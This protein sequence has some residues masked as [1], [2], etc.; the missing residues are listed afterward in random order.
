MLLLVRFELTTSRLPM[1][2]RTSSVILATL[3]LLPGPPSEVSP[4]VK[5]T[6]SLHV[7][8]SLSS[9]TCN[10]THASSFQT[11]SKPSGVDSFH[12]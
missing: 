4:E 12:T 9:N 5:H 3:L 6:P 7:P 10:L 2:K 1:A 11:H 8:V